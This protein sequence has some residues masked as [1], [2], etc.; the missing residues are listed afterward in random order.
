VRRYEGESN[1]SGSDVPPSP[2]GGQAAT[3]FLQSIDILLGRN[4]SISTTSYFFPE[5]KSFYDRKAFPWL[6][7]VEADRQIRAEL[8][9][10]LK[11]T[12]FKPYVDTIPEGPSK[13]RRE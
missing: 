11:Q 10:V 9:K 3:R 8:V 12:P 2:A 13:N 6:D 1:P 7:K 5:R 4:K